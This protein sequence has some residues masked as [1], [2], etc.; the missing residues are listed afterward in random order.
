MH[1]H[2]STERYVTNNFLGN[3]LNVLPCADLL[4][5][6]H[7]KVLLSTYQIPLKEKKKKKG[8]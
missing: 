4:P 8:P 2:L 6:L 7:M 1:K 5:D 3:P